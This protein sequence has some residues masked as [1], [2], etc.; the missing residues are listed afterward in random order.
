MAAL[1]ELARQSILCFAGYVM[2]NEDK[3]SPLGT[4]LLSAAPSGEPKA[5][6]MSC[7]AG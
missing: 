3:K 1:V 6:N 7:I 5:M 4:I 2:A